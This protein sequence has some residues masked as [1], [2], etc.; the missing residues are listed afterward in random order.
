[1]LVGGSLCA[2][3]HIQSPH[4]R[5]RPF[6]ASFDAKS[7]VSCPPRPPIWVQVDRWERARRKDTLQMYAVPTCGIRTNRPTVVQVRRRKWRKGRSEKKGPPGAWSGATP[8]VHAYRA[9]RLFAHDFQPK[10]NAAR[11]LPLIACL[12]SSCFPF[13]LSR[14][15]IITDQALLLPSC[16]PSA[17]RAA[18]R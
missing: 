14:I 2:A 11:L 3:S 10:Y 12:L 5:P 15:L 6:S 17:T 9:V 13:S 18:C 8:T 16:S 1:M 7:H 4:A